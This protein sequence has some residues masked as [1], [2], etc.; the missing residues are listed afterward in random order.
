MSERTEG[1]KSLESFENLVLDLDGGF[2]L[3]GE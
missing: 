1:V 3:N 2:S